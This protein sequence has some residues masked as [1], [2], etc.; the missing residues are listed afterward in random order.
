MIESLMGAAAGGF[1]AMIVGVLLSGF[2][3]AILGI[4]RVVKK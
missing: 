4:K 1:V 2:V 3:L